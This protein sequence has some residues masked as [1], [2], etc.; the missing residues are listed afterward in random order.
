MRVHLCG[1]RGSAPAPGCAFARV[2]GNTSCVALAHDREERPR[3]VLDAG[4]GLSLVTALLGGAPFRGTLLLGHLHWDHTYGIPFFRGGSH[5]D[6]RV[7]VLLPEQGV[8]ADTLVAR[9]MSPP[10][11]PIGPF[12]LRGEWTYG[13]LEEGEHDIEDF[14]VLAR[15]IPHPGGRTFGYRVSD[16][17]STVAYLSDHG[18]RAILGPGPDGWG[19]YH[20][21]ALDLCRDADLMIHDAQYTSAELAERAHFGHSAAEYAVALARRARARRLLLFHHDPGRTDD[22][23]A[24]LVAG[25]GGGEGLVVEAAEEGRTIFLT[26]P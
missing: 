12:E 8:Q 25:F 13:T 26:G 1:V 5:P 19:P 10:T 14:H 21:A 4:T 20:Q 2:G 6:A 18:P 16:A 22:E 17:H 3:L 15:E 9:F 23:V 11:F 7:R 24:A